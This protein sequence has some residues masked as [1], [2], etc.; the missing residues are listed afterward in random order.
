MF[1][2]TDRSNNIFVFLEP[3]EV[4]KLELE[5]IQGKYINATKNKEIGTL[6]ITVNDSFCRQKMNKIVVDVQK[7][8]SGIISSMNMVI[9][10]RVYDEIAEDGSYKDHEGFRHLTIV[11]SSRLDFYLESNYNFF[12]TL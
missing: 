4:K 11:D 3:D 1:G 10:Q 5:K 9:M 2:Y 8:P 6:E 7:L 12:K